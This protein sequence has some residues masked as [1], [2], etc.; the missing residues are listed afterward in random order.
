[1]PSTKQDMPKPAILDVIA[2][3]KARF[4]VRELLNAAYPQ[5]ATERS[6]LFKIIGEIADES[7]IDDLIARIEGKDPVARLHII[8]VL[9]RF[10][11]P[12]VQQAVQRQLK[13]N[14]KLIRSAALSA[15]A[16]MDG[17]FDIALLSAHAARSGDRGAEQGRRRGRQGQSPGNRQV[18]GRGAQG[19]E[20]IRA[21]R[22][23]RGAERGRQC[24]I[25]QV[26]ARGD[27]RQRLVGAHP[28][29]RRARQDRRPAR[30]R[31]G[32]HP[33]QGREPGHSP[34]RHRD[35]QSDQGRARRGAA[36]RGDQG[37]RLVGERARRGRPGR[38]RQHQGAAALH[39]D[40]AGRRGRSRC[41]R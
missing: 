37:P 27:R 22:R 35:P 16:R 31:C 34:R 17:P 20:R 26:P 14:S 39:R 30:G 5:E 12:D 3:Q 24:E 40:A 2:A 8:K 10:N 4:T 1:M 19:R 21:A 7:S 15:L 9:S 18:P 23:G 13:D 11:R 29:G 41:R 6:G 32:A 36:D 33:D 28:R 25:G 38:D